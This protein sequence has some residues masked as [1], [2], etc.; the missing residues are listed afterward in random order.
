MS[1]SQQWASRRYLVKE[2]PERVAAAW[3]VLSTTVFSNSDPSSQATIKGIL[4]LSH[5]YKLVKYSKAGE[6]DRI[7][8]VM[9]SLAVQT[10]EMLGLPLFK[11]ADVRSSNWMMRLSAD[12]VACE[13]KFTPSVLL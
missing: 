4:E 11:G 6:L 5:L 8:K 12:Q 7:N 10:Q 1:K 3:K 13:L 2:L 9:V